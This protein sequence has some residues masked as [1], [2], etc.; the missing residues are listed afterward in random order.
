MARFE[1]ASPLMQQ[2]ANALIPKM[3]AGLQVPSAP[4][5]A[6][7]SP[8]SLGAAFAPQQVANVAPPSQPGAAVNAQ[9]QVT[10]KLSDL[11]GGA[12]LPGRSVSNIY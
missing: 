4:T 12:P 9:P 2:I 10:G 8:A 7:Q 5:P 1:G 6:A 3:V 11:F